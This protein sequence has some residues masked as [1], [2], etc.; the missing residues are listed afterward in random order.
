MKLPPIGYI[1]LGGVGLYIASQAFSSGGNSLGPICTATKQLEHISC[2][3]KI[4]VT[5]PGGKSRRDKQLGFDAI[6]KGD[7]DAAITALQKDWDLAKDPETLIAL[8]NAKLAKQSSAKIKTIAVVVPSSQTPIFVPTSMLKG[9]AEAQREWNEGGHGWQLQ[10]VL[11]D[12]SNDVQVGRKVAQELVK[13]HDILAVLGHYS[14]NVSVNVREIYQ[15]AQVVMLSPTSTADE[16]TSKDP[17]GFFFRVVASNDLSTKVIAARWA[18]K[19]DKVALFY[20]PNKKASESFRKALIA[21]VGANRIVKELDLTQPNNAAQE[22]AAVKAAGAKAIVLIPDAYTDAIER[23]RVLSIIKANQ[24]QLPILGNS[25]VRDP[26]LFQA[27]PK[28][29]ANLVINVPINSDDRQSIDVARLAQS[30]NWWGSKSQISDRTINSYDAMQVLLTATDKVNSRRE[31]QQNLQRSD[32]VARG[33]T[34]K[35]SF[36]G[37][38]RAEPITSLITPLCINNKCDGFQTIP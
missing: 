17:N 24:G 14:S 15:Q 9:I 28:S 31:V 8:N 35:I 11:A 1:V 3:E 20:T 38:D 10:V 21:R 6:Q 4:L 29:L 26:Y 16:L 34:G 32:F 22:I 33:I 30:P 37:S 27:E 36:Q 12:D 5:P 23:D 18:S 19:Y 13:Y 25:V 7:Y 2:G